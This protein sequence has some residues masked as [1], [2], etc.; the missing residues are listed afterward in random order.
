MQLQ[1]LTM[2]LRL[3]LLWMI[4]NKLEVSSSLGILETELKNFLSYSHI[5]CRSSEWN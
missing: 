5:E 1:E 2:D 4:N 3:E